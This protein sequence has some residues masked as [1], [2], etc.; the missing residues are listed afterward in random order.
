MAKRIAGPVA[1]L[2]CAFGFAGCGAQR[3]VKA[4]AIAFEPTIVGCSGAS[5]QCASGTDVLL[6]ESREARNHRCPTD[7]PNVLVKT[8]GALVCVVALRSAGSI[9]AGAPIP[10]A[11]QRSGPEAVASF[12][13]GKYRL[14]R[15]RLPCLSPTQRRRE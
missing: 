12:R 9:A 11:V 13:A 10:N 1:V 5:T 3:T 15:Y 8:D 2:C 4:D 6:R 7:K 14:R